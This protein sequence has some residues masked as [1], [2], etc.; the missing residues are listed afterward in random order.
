MQLISGDVSI[1]DAGT[2]FDVYRSTRGVRVAVIDGA[3]RLYVSSKLN[4][5]LALSAGMMADVIPS[6][7]KITA[8]RM[9]ADDVHKSMSWTDGKLYFSRTPLSVAIEEFN[10]YNTRQLI[11]VSHEIAEYPVSGMF[12]TT[13]VDAFINALSDEGI[14]P[15]P[16]D[17]PP[18]NENVIRLGYSS[19]PKHNAQQ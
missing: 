3:V 10:R 8:V 13:G 14:V 1:V 18:S 2:K 19:A 4:H 15:L 9:A 11:T 5:S 17:P 7:S 6:A 16:P 12:P